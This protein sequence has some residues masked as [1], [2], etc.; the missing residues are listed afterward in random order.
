MLVKFQTQDRRDQIAEARA[1]VTALSLW[2]KE[3]P[4]LEKASP[5]GISF[6][7]DGPNLV[8]IVV[9]LDK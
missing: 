9:S 6:E 7:Y 3:M 8:A 2:L 1:T 4:P 5:A